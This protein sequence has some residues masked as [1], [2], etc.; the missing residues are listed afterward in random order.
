M[1]TTETATYNVTHYA[2]EAGELKPTAKYAARRP[3]PI[4]QHTYKGDGTLPSAVIRNRCGFGRCRLSLRAA[5]PRRGST[6]TS[7]HRP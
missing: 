3:L 4:N 2:W 6:S 1:R 5:P 7:L